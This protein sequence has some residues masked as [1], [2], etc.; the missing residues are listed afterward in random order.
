[1]K[2]IIGGIFIIVGIMVVA[3]SGGDCDGKCME[4]ANST[5]EMLEISLYGILAV[6]FGGYLVYSS[7]IS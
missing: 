7:N 5:S 6:A 1:M 2:G 3:G 4:L